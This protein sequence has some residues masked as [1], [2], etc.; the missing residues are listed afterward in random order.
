V[1]LAAKLSEA[2]EPGKRRAEEEEEEEV[3][4]AAAASLSARATSRA[5]RDS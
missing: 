2:E 3:A 4:A 5:S 1:E